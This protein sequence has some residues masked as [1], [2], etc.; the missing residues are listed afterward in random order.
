[1]KYLSAILAVLLLVP[2]VSAQYGMGGP[3]VVQRTRPVVSSYG[4]GVIQ[5]TAPVRTVARKAVD[6]VT[7]PIVTTVAPVVSQPQVTYW[8][9]APVAAPV[10]QWQQ[11]VT[12]HQPVSRFQRRGR[13]VCNGKS[14]QWVQ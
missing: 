1:M 2:T 4:L 14:C 13:W 8:E 3:V 7:P 11:P 9:P 6:I 5:R 12:W 10:V